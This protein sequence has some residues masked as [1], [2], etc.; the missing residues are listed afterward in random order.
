MH[1][2]KEVQQRKAE[3]QFGVPAELSELPYMVTQGTHKAC[4]LYHLLT[5]DPCQTVVL[6]K[7]ARAFLG[8]HLQR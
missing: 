1:H 4:L 7:H 8:T 3:L 6:D 2:K 5:G